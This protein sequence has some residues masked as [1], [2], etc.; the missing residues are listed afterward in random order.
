MGLLRRN[1]EV[2]VGTICPKC[3]MEFSEPE[4]MLRHM[5]KAHKRKRKINCNSCG[6]RN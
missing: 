2:I 4:R 3:N 6:F 1:K 5:V